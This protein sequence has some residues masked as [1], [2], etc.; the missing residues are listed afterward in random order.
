MSEQT[1]E[2]RLEELLRLA[3]ETHTNLLAD[4]VEG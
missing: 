2:E 4:P 3:W 1:A